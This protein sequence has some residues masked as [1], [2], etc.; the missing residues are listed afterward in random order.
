MSLGRAK[1]LS[2]TFDQKKHLIRFSGKDTV[3][4]GG[5]GGIIWFCWF[6]NNHPLIRPADIPTNRGPIVCLSIY[7]KNSSRLDP[8]V[9]VEAPIHLDPV[10]F[11]WEFI[12]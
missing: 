3:W 12:H 11:L 7:M 6:Y 4:G 10:I 1:L 2:L 8:V 5:V 9:V